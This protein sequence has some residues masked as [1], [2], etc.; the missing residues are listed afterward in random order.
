MGIPK[1]KTRA[2]RALELK[3]TLTRGPSSSMI[4]L[5]K[6]QKETYE[7]ARKDF[8]RWLNTWVTPEVLALV[9]ELRE[10]K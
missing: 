3:R 5:S 10:K 4:G 2:Y 8:M 1:E 7:E 6:E 9:P